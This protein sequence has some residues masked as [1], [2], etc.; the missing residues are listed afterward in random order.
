MFGM[1]DVTRRGVLTKAQAYK[2]VTAVLGS[3]SKLARENVA[4]GLDDKITLSKD[5][6]V[7]Y[8][9]EAVRQAQPS[10]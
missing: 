10:Q 4:D 1:F 8:M 3:S 6:F 2:A 7:R 5:Q 9:S